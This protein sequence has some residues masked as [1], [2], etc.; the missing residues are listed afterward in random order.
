MVWEGLGRGVSGKCMSDASP[1]GKIIIKTILVVDY[2][3]YQLFLHN[4]MIKYYIYNS[5]LICIGYN[6]KN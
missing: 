4:N 3:I 5:E 6:Q 2:F 1:S